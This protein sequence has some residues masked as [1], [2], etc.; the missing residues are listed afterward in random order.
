MFRVLRRGEFTECRMSD[1]LDEL[2]PEIE[3]AIIEVGEMEVIE[4]VLRVSNLLRK[5]R[6]RKMIYCSTADTRIGLNARIDLE[7][8]EYATK[9]LDELAADVIDE[10]SRDEGKAA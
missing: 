5:G 1:I 7:G 2:A 9:V 6:V 10:F 4:M 3:A 8:L